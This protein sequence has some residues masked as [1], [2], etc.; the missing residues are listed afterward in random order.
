MKVVINTC[1]GG[2]SLS[3]DAIRAWESRT[4]REF[5]A[6]DVPRHD[7]DLVAVVLLFGDEA[8][9]SCAELQVIT[10]DGNQYLITEYDGAETI[11]TPTTT[12]WITVDSETLNET[13]EAERQPLQLKMWPHK[14]RA[15]ATRM[16]ALGSKLR[17]DWQ[18]PHSEDSL[19]ETLNK[20]ERL[21]LSLI[22]I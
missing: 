20:G 9:G 5:D 17:A 22:H 10:I 19:A 11:R 1:Y 6:W 13:A 12:S 8:A 16:Q 7:P 3:D 18:M 2:F 21:D 14:Q 4:G 15:M